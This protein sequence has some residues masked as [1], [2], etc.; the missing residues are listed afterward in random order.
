MVESTDLRGD[1]TF[2]IQFLHVKTGLL[3]QKQQMTG[4]MTDCYKRL[5]NTT[6]D[7]Y[8]PDDRGPFFN[9]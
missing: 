5:K 6:C 1:A 8:N 3:I 9:L 4:R 2:F 7:I